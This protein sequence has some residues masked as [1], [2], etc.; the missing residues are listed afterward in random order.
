MQNGTPIYEEIIARFQQVLRQVQRQLKELKRGD[1][2]LFK[3]RGRHIGLVNTYADCIQLVVFPPT[4]KFAR[5]MVYDYR[6]DEPINWHQ[7]ELIVRAN[8]QTM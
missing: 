5:N 6:T 4:R 1:L 2:R 3:A 7:I 8:Y